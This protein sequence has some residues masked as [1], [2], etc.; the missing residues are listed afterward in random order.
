MLGLSGRTQGVVSSPGMTPLWWAQPQRPCWVGPLARAKGPHH[1]PHAYTHTHTNVPQYHQAQHAP[2]EPN[3][4]A[5]PLFLPFSPSLP[6]SVSL[7]SPSIRRVWGL[8]NCWENV[9]NAFSSL[10]L[11]L[12]HLQQ[13]R[14]ES[15]F[16]QHSTCQ[17]GFWSSCIANNYKCGLELRHAHT[18]PDTHTYTYVTYHAESVLGIYSS[19]LSAFDSTVFGVGKRAWVFHPAAPSHFGCL[20]YYGHL[21]GNECYLKARTF[22]K[23]NS[24]QLMSLMLLDKLGGAP[25]DC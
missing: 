21:V 6:L 9:Q 19:W 5:L 22:I 7:G 24:L 2:M 13:N 12:F 25:E 1:T 17:R 3:T 4:Q 18:Q 11:S 23:F 20:T 16:A 10:L 8:F 14:T 15:P